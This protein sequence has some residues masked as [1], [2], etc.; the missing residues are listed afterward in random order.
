MLVPCKQGACKCKGFAWIPSRAEDVGEFWMQRRRDFDPST[1]RA[2]C[3]CKHTHEQHDPTG[4]R[5]CKT[6][7]ILNCSIQYLQTFTFVRLVVTEILWCFSNLKL[8]SCAL[9]YLASSCVIESCKAFIFY[10]DLYQCYLNT[11]IFIQKQL[12]L[13]PNYTF[14]LKAPSYIF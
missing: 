12:P 3:K 5:R 11:W 7:L 1:W 6:G 13:A 2:K 9:R 14:S 10:K 8:C 4:M